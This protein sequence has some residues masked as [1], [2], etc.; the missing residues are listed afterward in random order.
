MI[1]SI[2]KISILYVITLYF[3]LVTRILPISLSD[4]IKNESNEKKKYQNTEFSLEERVNDLVLH[5]TLEEKISQ[6]KFNAPAIERLNIPQYNWWNE[7]L[8]GVARAGIATVFPQAIAL[9]AT[10]DTDMMYQVATVI[11][12]EAR[13]KYHYAIKHDNHIIYHGLTFWS[14]NINIFRDPRWGRGQETYGEDP[15]LTAQMGI[16]FIKGLQ[17]ND[18]TYFKV[19]ATPKHFAVHSGPEPKRHLFNAVVNQRVLWDTYLPAF[20]ACITEGKAFSIMGAYNRTNGEPCCASNTLLKDILRDKWKFEGYVVSDCGAIHDIHAYH[21]Y[22]TTTPEAVTIAVKAGCDLNCGNQYP[23]LLEAV[24]NGLITEEI[25]DISVKRLF[26]ARFK[27][28]MLDPEKMVPYTSLPYEIVDCKKHRELARKASCASIVLLKNQ[29]NLLPLRKDLSSIAVV[30]PNADN[31][32]VLLGNYH[33]TSS[34]YVTILQGIKNK[35]AD[36]TTIRYTKGCDLATSTIPSLSIVPQNN[37]TPGIGISLSEIKGLKG[38][39]FSNMTLKGEPVITRYDSIIDFNWKQEA[40]DKNLP[41]DNFSIRW[42]GYLQVKKSG[43]YTLGLTGDDGYR[44]YIN[45]NKIIDLWE[46]HSATT[47]ISK[48]HLKKN[49]TYTIRLEYYENS[50][51]ASIT[52]GWNNHKISKKIRKK[53]ENE[54]KKAVD[55]ASQSEIVIMVGGLSPQ[56]EGEEMNTQRI[57]FQ[58]GDRTHIQLPK[59]Q[60]KL[61]KALYQTKT[62]VVLILLN[63]SAL[64]VNWANKHILAILEAWYPGEEGGNGVADVLFGDYNP[65]GRLS[66]TFYKSVKQLPCFEDYSMKNITYRYFKGDVLYP[67]GYGLSYSDFKYSNLTYSSLKIGTNDEIKLKVD[68]KNTGKMDGDEVVQVY[69]SDLKSSQFVP[70]KSLRDFKRIHIK[71][72][73]SKTVTFNLNKNDFSIVNG[74]GKKIIEPGEFEIMVGKNSLQGSKTKIFIK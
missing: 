6:M 26:K 1:F 24:Q 50:G 43:E 61:L 66:V 31:I 17:G 54:L 29:D 16:A 19:I 23:Y 59:P 65:A 38:E 21:K 69:V 37:L 45:D 52:F 47:R 30:G 27:L 57:G 46:D 28:G 25:I 42:T 71:A 62:P 4:N 20:E 12:D 67:F 39:Y 63:G 2:K 68:I 74:Q 41:S 73:S 14:P 13:A 3:T 49:N 9:A 34:Q 40:P 15:Y 33:G 11:S 51:D 36:N 56:L 18:S 55:L 53:S 22:V 5:M 64:A 60:I 44:L 58:G 7:C 48:I 10:W 35:V 70:I 32:E 72:G 8:H